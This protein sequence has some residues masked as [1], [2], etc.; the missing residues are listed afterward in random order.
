MLAEAAMEDD[1]AIDPEK[2]VNEDGPLL[3]KPE[4]EENKQ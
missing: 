4:E 3:Y 2:L 1:F